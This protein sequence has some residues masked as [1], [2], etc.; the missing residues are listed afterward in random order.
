MK[1]RYII[2]PRRIYRTL[3]GLMFAKLD[4]CSKGETGYVDAQQQQQ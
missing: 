1:A 3:Y 4:P 2:M